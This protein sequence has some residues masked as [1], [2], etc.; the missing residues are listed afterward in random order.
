MK[1]MTMHFTHWVDSRKSTWNQKTTGSQLSLRYSWSGDVA[2]DFSEMVM[3]ALLY[4]WNPILLRNTVINHWLKQFPNVGHLNCL[5]FFFLLHTNNIQI[6]VYVHGYFLRINS[7]RQNF[8]VNWFYGI[9][10]HANCLCWSLSPNLG[11]R[12]EGTHFLLCFLNGS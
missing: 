2:W 8:C 10:C 9:H 7:W 4:E 6:F 3:N 1:I 12:A 5:Y 11:K